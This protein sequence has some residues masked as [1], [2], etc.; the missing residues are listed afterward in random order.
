MKKIIDTDVLVLGGG[1]AGCAAAL[2]ALNSGVETVTIIEATP[3]DRHR[4]GEILLTNTI[5]DIHKLG[6][7]RDLFPYIEKYG[8]NKKF[9]AAYVHGKDR[10]PWQVVNNHPGIDIN[11]DD[12][13]NHPVDY[14]DPDSG[15]WF[16]LVV[17]RHEFDSALREICASKGIK[18]IHGKAVDCRIKN[19]D[20]PHESTIVSVD[21]I[22]LENDKI[23]CVPQFVIDATG[24]NA[25]MGNKR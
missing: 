16:T 17:R 6:I 13:A 4:I 11:E 7:A 1:P 18:I 20:S 9:A 12:G 8:W 5:Q 3:H 15:I 23:K 14:I 2:S 10:T 21:I 22:G 19:P 25:L 24:Q